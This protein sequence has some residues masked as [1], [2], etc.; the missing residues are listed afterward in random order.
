MISIKQ[1]VLIALTLLLIGC[2]LGPNYHT[3]PRPQATRYTE[4]AMPKS[5]VS[6]Q[7]KAGKQ[8]FFR[9]SQDI[10][11][12]WWTIFHSQALNQIIKDSLCA[13][14]D[15][16]AA[17]AAL[18]IAHENTLIQKSA[19]FPLVTANYNP[20]RQLTPGTL[21]S[22]VASNAYLYTLNTTN[23]SVTYMPDVL[24]FTRR[25]VESAA[26]KEESQAFQTEAI[27][28]TLTSNIVL[29]AIQEASIRAQI[30]FT[31]RSI[32]IAHGI[33]DSL[34]RQYSMG[35]VSQQSVIAQEVFLAQV[36]SALP[37]LQLQL[38]QQRHLIASL[39]GVPPSESIVQKFSLDDFTLPDELPVKLPAQ[40]VEQRP[41]VRAAEAQM[42][43]ASAQIGVAFANRFPNLTLS[44]NGG[45]AP[46]DF[47]MNS[48]PFAL[49]LLPTGSPFYWMI[50]A[51]L[52]G[53]IF[54][55]GSLKHQQRAAEAAYEQT[56][57]QYRRVVL[58]AFQN[59]ADSLK[60]I[61]YDAKI[62]KLA[63][64]QERAA[65]KNVLIIKK[66]LD[67]GL[68]SYL[69]VLNAEQSYQQALANLAQSQ[70]NRFTDT[71]GLFQ[72]LGGGWR[73]CG[74]LV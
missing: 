55:A 34:Q 20:M 47:A 42:H 66:K 5:T 67:L 63:A 18:K 57:A 49:P 48:I 69:E 68:I 7:T 51:N 13:N 25:Q 36:E 21:A 9:I 37:S 2:A 27:Y 65:H 64:I 50:F 43:A 62:L 29:A 71:V 38:A 33:L 41:D 26:A 28:L 16:A 40:L 4:K 59:V 61:Q 15:I 72:A 3:P 45:I 8:Q 17:K 30:K 22:N 53:T 32:K 31:K 46:I 23:L 19:F 12:K 14:P 6:A 73:G 10:P 24:G 44:A 1:V 11:L 39:R 52:A 74:P 70:A 35:A 58:N 54:D 60:A 56:V